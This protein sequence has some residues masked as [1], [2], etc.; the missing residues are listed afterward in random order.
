MIFAARWDSDLVGS[1]GLHHLGY[2]VL[3]DG[4]CES[5]PGRRM[6]ELGATGEQRVVTIGAHV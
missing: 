4:L 5:R 6:S 2:T 1:E 3:P